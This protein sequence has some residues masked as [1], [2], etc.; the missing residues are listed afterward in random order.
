MDIRNSV[1]VYLITARD[2]DQSIHAIAKQIHCQR[3]EVYRADKYVI[4]FGRYKLLQSDRFQ[5]SHLTRCLVAAILVS[6]VAAEY[7]H[8]ASRL[9]QHSKCMLRI[10]VPE[11]FVTAC[12]LY[13]LQIYTLTSTISE[14][15][16]VIFKDFLE[17]VC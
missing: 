1:I 2:E 12:V 7:L 11:V 9:T 15:K 8:F 6:S 4:M 3:S 14:K 13:M 16:L 17:L 5:C 10:F